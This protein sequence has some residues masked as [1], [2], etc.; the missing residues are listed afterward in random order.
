MVVA[1][2]IVQASLSRIITVIYALGCLEV[3]LQNRT[4]RRQCAR[5]ALTGADHGA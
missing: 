1:D 5:R 4:E 2:G 3:A